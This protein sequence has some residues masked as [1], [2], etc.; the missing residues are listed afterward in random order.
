[1]A[2]KHY[3]KGETT[4]V[5]KPSLCIHSANCVKNL[6]KVFN[7][8]NKP[9]IDTDKATEE[10]LINTIK[11]CP[12]GA[13]SY[14]IESSDLTSE[15]SQ[16]KKEKIKV[17]GSGPLIISDGCSIEYKGEIIEKEGIVAL[18]RCGHSSNKPF[19]DGSHRI[20]EFND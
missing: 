7:P 8:N 10:E 1:M 6:P 12:S 17:M 14:L 9:W 4:V 11:K 16:V 3:K 2:E 5:W 19:C 20:K 13:L 15:I 18:C